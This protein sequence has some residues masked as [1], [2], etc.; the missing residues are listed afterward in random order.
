MNPPPRWPFIFLTALSL[1]IGWGIRGNFGHETGAMIPGALAAM[2]AVLLSRREDWW[3]RIV[4]FA[5]FG[6]L[7]W[8]FSG[9]ISYMQVIAYTH[10]GHS[11]SVLYGFACL[12]VI[13]LLWAALGGAGTALAACLSREQLASFFGPITA[14]FVAWIIQDVGEAVI[15]NARPNY[16]HESPLY[17]YDTDWL[18]VSTAILAVLGW[19]VARRRID[20]ACS[21]ILHMAMGWWIGFLV[22]VVLLGWRMTPPRG[23]NW[24]GCVGMVIGLW[25]YLRRHGFREVLAVSLITGF[26]GGV[27]FAGATLL[28]LMFVKTGWQT[29]WHSVLEQIYGFINGIGV[30]LAMLR[31]A[32]R[33]KP[34]ADEPSV[35]RWTE[36][37]ATTFVLI[38]ITYL[39]LRKNPGVWV[40]AKTISESIYGLTPSI[41]FGIGY[42]LLATAVVGLM[43]WHCRNPLDLLPVSWLGRGQ[44]LYLAFL[45]WMVVGNFERALVLFTPQRIVTEGTIFLNAVICTILLLARPA[46]SSTKVIDCGGHDKWPLRRLALVG[47]LT[48]IF[49]VFGAW[50]IVRGLYGDQFAGQA[51]LH[52]R[53]GPNATATPDKPAAGQP[54]P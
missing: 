12:F 25:V 47:L 52:V 6:A 22:L 15:V 35:R 45:W 30:A 50:G 48:M 13:G 33:A 5:F 26:W 19:V 18:G 41:W 17:W 20:P 32:K 39:N 27:G 11:A 34:V 14:I 37:Y 49:T 1:S 40:S 29:N 24:A 9:S 38:G 8:S 23:D 36:I 51:R 43:A 4:F 28:K 21:L 53:F 3:Q 42:A 10:S 46:R 31:L 2:A 54:H 44:M 7:G 16:R